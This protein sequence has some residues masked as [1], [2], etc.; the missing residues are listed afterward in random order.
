MEIDDSCFSSLSHP[1]LVMISL[2]VEV[3]VKHSLKVKN[4][5][6][7]VRDFS[8]I[9]QKHGIMLLLDKK[10]RSEV[11]ESRIVAQNENVVQAY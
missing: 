7:I 6:Q 10:R 11:Q 8:D 3:R 2:F 5:P 1:I 9:L 4:R